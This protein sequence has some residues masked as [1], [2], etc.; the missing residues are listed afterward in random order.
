MLQDG[1][2]ETARCEFRILHPCELLLVLAE[3]LAAQVCIRLGQLERV[4][5]GLRA[6]FDWGKASLPLKDR[7]FKGKCLE[8]RLIIFLHRITL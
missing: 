1:P 4:K 6:F 7:L 5:V 2:V 3:R 8:A